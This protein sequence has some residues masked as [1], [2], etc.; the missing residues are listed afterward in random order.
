MTAD[1][2]QQ[3]AWYLPLS[4]ET[5]DIPADAVE[6]P[7]GDINL[8]DAAHYLYC[9]KDLAFGWR[10]A[11]LM[12]KSGYAVPALL[13]GADLWVYRAYLHATRAIDDPIIS[14]ALS[15][16][17]RRASSARDK[18]RAMLLSPGA[19]AAEVAV[20]MG[21][22]QRVIEAYEKLFFNVLD[23]KEEGRYLSEIVY[24][25]GRYVELMRGYLENEPLGNLLMRT[26]Y[27]NGMADVLYMSG[28]PTMSLEAL[29]PSSDAGERF[30]KMLMM[31]GYAL[32]RSGLLNQSGMHGV[33][34]ARQVLQAIRQGGGDTD[35]TNPLAG[36]GESLKNELMALKTSEARKQVEY[37]RGRRNALEEA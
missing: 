4:A 24:P 14:Q 22:D 34:H 9:Y 17:M 13:E 25:D 29:L 28:V 35:D 26:G 21:M 23:R 11:Y 32:A 37:R 1:T 27:N 10:F 12:A 33:H 16:T 2:I 30:E 15:L 31:N 20:H 18:I 5:Q 7:A 6:V 19:T 8:Q 3:L 36:A